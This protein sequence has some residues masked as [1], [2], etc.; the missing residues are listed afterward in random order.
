MSGVAERY[1]AIGVEYIDH[2]RP[3]PRI[4]DQIRR[5]LGDARTVV[6]VGAGAGSYEPTT[7]DVVAVEPSTVMIRQ[8]PDGAAPVVQGYAEA[9]PFAD[10]SF[11]VAL[12]TFTV[13]HWTDVPR[14][15][16]EVRRV[17]G[18]Q[19]VLTFDQADLFLEEFWLTRDYLPR[20]AFTGDA[21]EGIDL[22]LE[23]LDVERVEI[24]PVP[25]DCHDGFFAAYW[26]RPHAY[27]DPRVRRSISALALVDEAT[28]APG[29]ARLAA[30]LE[31][32]A[33]ARRN[34]DLLARDEVDFGY[35][36]VVA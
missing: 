2:R 1:D 29:L 23:H 26:R 28:L 8:R 17:S 13:H 24:V 35:R 16:A 11:D 15:L 27:L 6:N 10:R 30:D 5:A 20:E 18:R 25:A 12:A 4:A 34:H 33:W 31:T 14:G 36:L 7:L 9:L 32:G 22:V 19:V 21:I 3:D